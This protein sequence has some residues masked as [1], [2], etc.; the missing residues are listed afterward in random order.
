MGIKIEMIMNGSLTIQPVD[1]KKISTG[2][3]SIRMALIP[4]S[5]RMAKFITGKIIF[6]ER[7]ET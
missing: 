3:C 5:A 1:A 2:M 4:M 7:T 6:P